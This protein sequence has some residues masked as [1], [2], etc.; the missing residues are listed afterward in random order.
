[1]HLTTIGALAVTGISKHSQY[2]EWMF[3][4]IEDRRWSTVGV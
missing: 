1:M 3:I 2:T 4:E